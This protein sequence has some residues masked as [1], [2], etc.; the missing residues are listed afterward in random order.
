MS[1]NG[2]D[3]ECTSSSSENDVCVV[4]EEEVLHIYLHD[5][6][7][8]GYVPTQWQRMTLLETE[9]NEERRVAQNRVYLENWQNGIDS[10]AP[11]VQKDSPDYCW[12]CYESPRNCLCLASQLANRPGPEPRVCTKDYPKQFIYAGE[13]FGRKMATTEEMEK[14]REVENQKLFIAWCEKQHGQSGQSSY[15]SL[16]MGDWYDA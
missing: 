14:R 9:D 8:P 6:E 1:S 15:E 7:R 11:E 13:C 3:N 2:S 16:G 5:W 10:F 12:R 4:P